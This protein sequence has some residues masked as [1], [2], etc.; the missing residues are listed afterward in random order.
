MV[1]LTGVRIA[2]VAA[3]FATSVISARL[4]GPTALGAAGVGLTGGMVA[5][6]IGNG[7]LNIAAIYLLGR[8][9]A[10]RRRISQALFTLG[11]LSAG[12]S[13]LIVA[14][15]GALL[16]PAVLGAD[17]GLLLAS[18]LLGASIVGYELGG[19]LLLG[20]D[21]RT[22]YLVT[23]GI[24][25]LGSLALLVVLFVL[26]APTASTYVLSAA[27]AFFLAAAWA[28]LIVRRVVGGALLRLD[29]VLAREALALG[30]RGQI[31]NVLQF[32]NLRLDLLLVPL[33]VD[34]RSAG[35]YLIAV[36]MS[37]VV[38]QV[39]SAASAFLFQ[40]VARIE[41]DQTELTERATRATLL[42]VAAGGGAILLPA[43]LLLEVFFGPEYLA[44]TGALRI[45]MLA[46]LPLAVTRVL[47][48]DMK[49]RGRP[50]L[51]SV[52]AGLAL[53]AT[54]AFDLLLI[55]L[56]GI[57]G[58]AIAS[59]LAYSVG[60]AVLLYAYRRVSGG[61]LLQLVPRWADVVTLLTV[62]ARAGRAVFRG[63]G[64]AA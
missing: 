53:V 62:S 42:V 43:G 5:A 35:I 47:A 2:A 32:L 24:E 27:L 48:G 7:G 6:L 56:L 40:A 25:G 39:A 15:A 10:E 59:L 19:S 52:S 3:G 46:M 23:Q 17:L 16:V 34:L 36:R 18:A 49:G 60:A 14:V 44:G 20:L 8:R 45:T 64:P 38:T 51:V 63:R 1:V 31:G 61:S 50:G 41:P 12:L 29:R 58:A 37:E 21:R 57:E 26:V 33:L 28:V 9:P 13:A 30:L 55:P 4:L 11:L 22:A 54:V